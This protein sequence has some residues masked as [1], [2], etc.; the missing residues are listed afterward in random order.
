MRI[1][2]DVLLVD[3]DESVR[4]PLCSALTAFDLTCDAVSD[5]HEA[6]IRIRAVRY[7]VVLADLV[8]PAVDTGI[9]IAAINRREGLD[10]ALPVVLMMSSPPHAEM[11]SNASSAAQAVVRKPFD[12]IELAEIVRDC[13]DVRRR[14]GANRNGDAAAGD[15]S[16]RPPAS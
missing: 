7:G 3:E 14:I 5:G 11:I 4:T 6:L 8:T 9:F 16:V 15:D 13:I 1:E 10:P 12:V 2:K